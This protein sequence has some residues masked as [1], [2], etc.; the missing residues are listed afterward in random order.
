MEGGPPIFTLRGK[1][2]SLRKMRHVT[3]QHVVKDTLKYASITGNTTGA[4][5]VIGVCMLTWYRIMI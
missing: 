3:F 5:L 1:E 4:N 2:E